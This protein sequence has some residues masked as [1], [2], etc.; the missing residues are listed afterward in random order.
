MKHVLV[1]VPNDQELAARLGKRG[2]SN[3]VTFYNRKDGESVFAILA[4]TDAEKKFNSVAEVL[5]ISDNV[6][7]STRSIDRLFGESI[8]GCGLL[9][10]RAILTDDQDAS[11]IMQKSGLQSE[12][13][14]E[15]RLLSYLSAQH[16][17]IAGDPIVEVDHSFDVKGVGVVLLG[18]VRSGVIRVHDELFCSSGK[19]VT[20]RSLQSQDQDINEAEA[21][22]R[23]GIAIKGAESD[24]ISKGDILSRAEI[25]KTQRIKADISI[26]GLVKDKE[27]SYS[28]LWLVCGF[29]S[30]ACKI[31]KEGNYFEVSMAAQLPMQPGER[32]LLVRKESPRIFACGTVK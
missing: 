3:G 1:A 4:P 27:L 29:R 2:S 11:A 32:F 15:D 17:G 9:G 8:I 20:V 5:T 6:V 7:V 24:D 26:S 31:S 21:N 22:T 19:R 25:R 23:V 28:D 14:G 16:A 18:I 12:V 10:R 13:M 30:S